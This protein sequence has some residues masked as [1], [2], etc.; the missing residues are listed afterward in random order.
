MLVLKE[1]IPKIFFMIDRQLSQLLEVKLLQNERLTSSE[2]ASRLGMSPY[3]AGKLIK[4]AANFSVDKI[5]GIIK[6]SL[7][8]DVGIKTGQIGDRAALE[9][10]IA[11]FVG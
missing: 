7:S 10:I 3:I 9:L 1:P 11:R 4:Q 2:I 8:L 6:E 5:K